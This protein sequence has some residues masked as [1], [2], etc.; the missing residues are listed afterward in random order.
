MTHWYHPLCGAFK[1]PEPILAFLAAKTSTCDFRQTN[2]HGLWLMTAG[3]AT[4]NP[5]DLLG[6]TR[7]SRLME[8]VDGALV[9]P[10]AHLEPVGCAG[11]I[12]DQDIDASGG[13]TQID[14]GGCGELAQAGYL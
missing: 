12:T 9:E 8:D 4:G 14:L 6:S 11:Y 13:G 10:V 3:S 7:F 5:A 1:R 2:V